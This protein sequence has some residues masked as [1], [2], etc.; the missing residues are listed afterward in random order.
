MT[1]KKA[2]YVVQSTDEQLPKAIGDKKPDLK[3][4]QSHVGGYI[5]ILPGRLNGRSCSIVINE[6]G[7]I[8]G[9]PPN[10]LAT[11][12][13]HEYYKWKFKAKAEDLIDEIAGPAVIL[14]GYRL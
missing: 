6:E 5:Q 13:W 8:Y 2:V 7:K 4:L 14:E 10:K 1:N 9:M 3:E 12:Y 11:E